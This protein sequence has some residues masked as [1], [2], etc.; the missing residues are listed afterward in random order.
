MP[1]SIRVIPGGPLVNLKGEVVG[2]NQAIARNASGI[3]F[4]IP[5]NNVKEVLED[6]KKYGY[7]R[8]AFIGVNFLQNNMGLEGVIVGNVVVQ[9]PAQRAGVRAGDRII[10]FNGK[11]IKNYW[12]LPDAVRKAKVGQKASITIVRENKELKL[13][14]TPQIFEGEKLSS[15]FLKNPDRLP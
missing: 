6:L 13:N 5:I 7:V 11:K 12:D 1:A 3:S 10:S 2:V 9:S 14:I 15:F 8:K 4:A